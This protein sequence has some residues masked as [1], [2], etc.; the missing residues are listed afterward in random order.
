[1]A[2]FYGGVQGARGQ[3]HR[4]G[5]AKSGITVVA[6]SYQGAVEV[7]LRAVNGLDHA[8]VSFKPWQGVGSSLP[9]YSGPV[10]GPLAGNPRR[11]RGRRFR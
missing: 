2:R 1:M 5:T 8:E 4:L 6:A 10:S 7:R 3:A 11:G 9:I